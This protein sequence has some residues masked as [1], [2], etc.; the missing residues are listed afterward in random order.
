M[1]AF[2]ARLARAASGTWRTY[3]DATGNQRAAAIAYHVL[4]SLVPF[5]ALFVA[6]GELVLSEAAQGRVAEW[7]TESFPLPESVQEGVA[8]VIANAGPAASV[9]GIVALLGLLWGASGMMASIRSAFRVIWADAEGDPYLRGKLVDLAL[10]LGAGVVAVSAFGLTVIA[11]FVASAST[12]PSPSSECTT[13]RARHSAASRNSAAHWGSRSSR[14]L[15]LYDIAPPVPTRMRATAPGALLA[16]VGFHLAS[17]GFSLYLAHVADFD[18]VYGPLGAVLALVLLVYVTA[19][20]LLVGAC[21]AVAWPTSADPGSAPSGSSLPLGRR[22]LTA[23]RGSSSATRAH[24]GEQPR[25]EGLALATPARL[26]ETCCDSPSP[27]PTS[28]EVRMIAAD[29]PFLES[30]G[31]CS[32]SSSGS[33]GS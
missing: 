13:T 33:R 20:V 14:F 19:I 15:L 25:H 31:R 2:A 9:A 18:D 26:V 30:S 12:E 28:T 3:S 7:L 10:V 16:T 23:A 29:Y 4:F 17:A 24:P 8:N 22:I 11:Q 27:R 32:S 1:S 21:F 6:L 5:V